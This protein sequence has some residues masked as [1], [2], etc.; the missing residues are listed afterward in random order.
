MIFSVFNETTGSPLNISLPK[1]SNHNCVMN[2]C[3]SF[4]HSWLPASTFNTSVSVPPPMNKNET[5]FLSAPFYSIFARFNFDEFPAAKEFLKKLKKGVDDV[6]NVRNDLSPSNLAILCLPLVMAVPPLSL[7]GP[8]S[9]AIIAWYAFATDILAAIPLMIK[10]IEM[11][12]L[13]KKAS[14]RMVSTLGLVGEKFQIFEMWDIQCRPPEGR[15]AQDGVTIVAVAFWF[16]VAST[17]VEFLFWREMRYREGRL[18][19]FEDNT[20]RLSEIEPMNS[21]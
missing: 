11:V 1:N 18:K 12:L 6:E 20:E 13:Y 9:D 15:V 16:M 19:E 17:Y 14:P 2:N 7:L 5:L 3:T 8:A 21:T 10:G 4:S